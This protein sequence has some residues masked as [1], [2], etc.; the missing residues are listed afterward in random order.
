MNLILKHNILKDLRE[1]KK[2]PSKTMVEKLN[3]SEDRYS[4]LE[5]KDIEVSQEFAE[6]VANIFKL[7]WAVFLLDQAPKRKAYKTDNRTHENKTPTL[8]ERTIN[9]LEDAHFILGFSGSLSESLKLKL[10]LIRDIKNLGP[11]ELGSKIRELSGVSIQD[12]LA[13]TTAA[14]AYK[15]WEKFI[16]DSGIFVSKYLLD[17]NDNVRAFSVTQDN[18]AIIVINTSDG[19]QAKIFS[20]IHEFCHILRKNEGLCDLYSS[21][22]NKVEVYCNMF[23]A[24]FLAPLSVINSYVQKNSPDEIRGDLDAHAIKL[25]NQL[26]ISKLAVLR[27]L[28]TIGV[29]SESTYSEV[30][31]SYLKY[32][33]RRKVDT[34]GK[35]ST[36]GNY[37]LTVKA[38]NGNAY[39][40]VILKA[41][42]SG[43]ITPVEAGSALGIS[44]D[45]LER[46]RRETAP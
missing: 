31:N 21:K 23:T 12:Q 13:F 14:E 44:V 18:Q 34:E 43:E 26:K 27:R 11:E 9:A 6:R 20:L 17:F 30:H 4:E 35:S 10:P 32:Y 40:K 22:S 2:I 29:I 15:R 19:N 39:S 7:N 46:Y 33:S 45:K 25:S 42:D 28:T 8:S 41:H 1:S 36:G 3:I 5:M 24:A 37:Y 38:H 16:E